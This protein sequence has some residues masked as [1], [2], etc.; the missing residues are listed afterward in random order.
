MTRDVHGLPVRGVDLDPATR[1][2]HY[3]DETDV[4]AIRAACCDAYYA[5]HACHAAV[6]DH[7]HEVIPTAEF[8][9]AAVLCG[10]CGHRLTVREYAD[11]EDACPACGHEFNPGCKR[12]WTR[13]FAPP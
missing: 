12:H 1:C 8:D 7:T 9:S 6:A 10:A 4:V 11:C 2:A 3:H 13:Y 5:C